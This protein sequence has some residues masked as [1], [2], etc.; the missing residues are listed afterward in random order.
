MGGV[1]SDE[2]TTDPG[3]VVHKLS[4]RRLRY[5]EVAAF[6]KVPAELPKIEDKDTKSKASFRL[7]G[8]DIPRVELRSKVMRHGAIRHGRPGFG[9]GLCGGAAARPTRAAHR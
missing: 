1:P 3:V 9:H 7:I 4:G 6:A 8:R 2:V 5:G